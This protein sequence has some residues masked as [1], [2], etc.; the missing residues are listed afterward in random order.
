MWRSKSPWCFGWDLNPHAFAELFESPL[1][2]DSSTETY[3]ARL[4]EPPLFTQ[5][6]SYRSV[7]GRWYR[8][9]HKSEACRPTFHTSAA[10]SAGQSETQR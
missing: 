5:V 1:S 6:T 7:Q 8:R 2:A 3:I 10:E 9:Q 4:S